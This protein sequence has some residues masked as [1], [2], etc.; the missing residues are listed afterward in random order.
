MN[1]GSKNRSGEPSGSRRPGLSCAECRRSKLKCD[2]SFPCQACIRR[3]CANICPEGTLNATKGNK[4]LMAHA[5]RMTEQITTLKARVEELEEALAKTYD[6]DH[7]L[8]RRSPPSTT[9][10]KD[11]DI[12][13]AIGSLSIGAHG[14]SKYHGESSSSEYFQDLL[15]ASDDEEPVGHPN[16]YDLRDEIVHLVDAFPFGLKEHRYNKELFRPY[17]PPRSTA[18]EFVNLYYSDAAWMYD[19]IILQEFTTAIL[20][21]MYGSGNVPSVEGIHPHELAVFFIIL[22]TGLLSHPGSSML[23]GKYHALSRAALSLEPIAVEATCS[24]IQAIFLTFR[25]LYNADRSYN[26]E[27]WLLTGVCVRL[28]QALGL[29]RDG[30]N[31]DLSHEEIQRRRRIFWELFVWDAWGSLVNGRPPALALRQTDCLYADEVNPYIN[32]DGKPEFSWNTW[33]QRYAATCMKASADH[34]FS[35]FGP[36]YNALLE[37]D[38]KIRNFIVPDYLHAPIDNVHLPLSWSQN[39]HIAIQQYCIMSVQESNLLYVHRSYFAQAIRQMPKNPLLH[40][41]ATS[42]MSTFRSARRVIAGLRGVYPISPRVVSCNWFFWSCTFSACVVLGALVVESPGCSLA[43]DA[44]RDLKETVPFYEEGSQPGAQASVTMLKKLCSRASA[45][46][47]SFRKGNDVEHHSNPAAVVDD[48]EV[49]SGRKTVITT[50]ARSSASPTI[51]ST[52]AIPVE[53]T[54]ARTAE[55]GLSQPGPSKSMDTFYDP[56]ES[57]P[58][59]SGFQAYSMHEGERFPGPAYPPTKDPTEG[60]MPMLSRYVQG[61]MNYFEPMY[62]SGQSNTSGLTMPNM[63]EHFSTTAEQQPS[64]PYDGSWHPPSS[65]GGPQQGTQG[66]G[67]QNMHF[68]QEHN[69]ADVWRNFI[70]QYGAK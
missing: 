8:L 22:A 10:E 62:L 49:L 55:A 35:L 58:N 69:Q 52:A 37:L 27:R 41:Y 53:A 65:L 42:V 54:L 64:Q 18:M 3:G 7:P 32:A 56:V 24:A 57:H 19:P 1:T 20:D 2:R 60:P 17:I 68:T 25:Y 59:M 6:G 5:Q 31:W 47:E 67:R 21:P 34:V 66:D 46:F 11:D 30:S 12:T 9:S 28:A 43:A 38:K 4:V 39:P 50:S 26:E 51:S 23:S 61:N 44:M 70:G 29:Q 33:K 40:K 16:P 45:A 36:S 15:E 63:P 14:Q 48:L 13:D